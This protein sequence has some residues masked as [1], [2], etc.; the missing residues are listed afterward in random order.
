VGGG[1]LLLGER[2]SAN[3]IAGAAVILA[4]TALVLGAAATTARPPR[5]TSAS[6]R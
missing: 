4:G 6:S 3:M 2:V 5:R 1:V